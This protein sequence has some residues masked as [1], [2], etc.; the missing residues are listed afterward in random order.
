MSIHAQLSPEALE[1][2]H[3]QRRNSTISSIAIAILTVALI[4]LALGIF[5]LPSRNQETPTIVT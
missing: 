5:L 4:A 3:R 1:R 2:L